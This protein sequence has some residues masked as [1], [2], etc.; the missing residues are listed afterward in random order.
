VWWNAVSNTAIVRHPGKQSRI[1]RIP[2][3]LTGLCS[4]ANGLSA[5]SSFNTSS[6]MRG[7]LGEALA[8]VDDAVRHDADLGGRADHAR[9]FR[10]QRRDHRLHGFRKAALR[11]LGRKLPSRPAVD[12]SRARDAD[13]LDLPVRMCASSAVS[14]KVYLSD[15]EPQLTTRIFSGRSPFRFKPYGSSLLRSAA[16]AFA[17]IRRQLPK[18]LGDRLRDLLD[19]ARLDDDDRTGRATPGR[20][21]P[22]SARRR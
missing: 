5:S 7:R 13:A 17:G 2:A 6:V 22:R 20:G 16:A 19:R 9:L 8:A 1:S 14:K 11:K 4:G 21:A 10:R 18:A 12:V 3:R 15:D